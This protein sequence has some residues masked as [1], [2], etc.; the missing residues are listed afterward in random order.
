MKFKFLGTAAA[1]GFPSM[2]CRCEACERARELGGI[3]LRSR[4]QALVNRDLLLDF[5][6]DTHSNARKYALHMDEIKYL[7]VTHSHLDH[8][9]CEDLIMRGVAFAHNMQEPLLKIYGNEQVRKPYD[10]FYEKEMYPPVREGYRFCE[11]S[12]YQKITAGEYEVIPLPARHMTTEQ[13]YIYVIRQGEKTVLYG[14]DTGMIFDQV[15]SFL[16]EANI[17]FNMIALDCTMVDNPAKDTDS[18]M[19]ISQNV[20][21]IDIL[22]KNGNIDDNTKVFATHFSHNGNPLQEELEKKLRQY[23]IAPT[24]DGLEVEV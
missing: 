4:S 2:F 17:Y 8:F 21:C 13:A 1:E 18:H 7:F 19:N 20:R 5:P 16:K 22:R 3:N 6:A 12:S 23:G 24:Y 10:F 15:F 9:T 14:T 11:V